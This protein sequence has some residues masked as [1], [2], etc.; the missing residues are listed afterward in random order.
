MSRTS[1]AKPGTLAHECEVF[2]RALTGHPP[3]P[4]LIAGY[5]RGHVHPSLTTPPRPVDE[6]LLAAARKGVWRARWADAYAALFDRRGL[7]RRKLVLLYALLETTAPTY[8]LFEQSPDTR[9]GAFGQ[10]ARAGVVGSVRLLAGVVWFGPRHL[11]G[12]RASAAHE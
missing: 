5:E 10:L 2:T 8:L 3:S 6:L 7:L 9:L 11:L 12:R 4:A 1:Q